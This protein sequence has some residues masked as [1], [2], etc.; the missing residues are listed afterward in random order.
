MNKRFLLYGI[1]ALVLVLVLSGGG[2]SASENAAFALS[3]RQQAALKNE[4]MKEI[5]GF[6][7]AARSKFLFCDCVTEKFETR[8]NANE[9]LIKIREAFVAKYLELKEDPRSISRSLAS[10]NAERFTSGSDK[11]DILLSTMVLRYPFTEMKDLSE[12]LV[13]GIDQDWKKTLIECSN[14]ETPLENK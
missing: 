6:D 1:V 9:E 8:I 2:D 5:V 12:S 14:V 4:C 3:V 13:T 10:R 11:V 7:Q